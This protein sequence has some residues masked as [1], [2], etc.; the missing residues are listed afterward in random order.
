MFDKSEDTVTW[1][2]LTLSSLAHSAARMQATF[3]QGPL[4]VLAQEFSDVVDK[5]H[6]TYAVTGD[7]D[8]LVL[9]RCADLVNDLKRYKVGFSVDAFREQLASL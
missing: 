2:N 3:E 8:A 9:L 4:V 7:V 6:E 5:L 1:K